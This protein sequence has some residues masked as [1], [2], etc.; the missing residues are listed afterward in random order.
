MAVGLM[1]EHK[2]V[3]TRFPPFDKWRSSK[4]RMAGGEVRRQMGASAIRQMLQRE[5]MVRPPNH[6]GRPSGGHKGRA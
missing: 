1:W 5:S 2:T 6:N 4:R 3:R